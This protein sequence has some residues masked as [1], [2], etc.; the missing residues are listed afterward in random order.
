MEEL[1]RLKVEQNP[2]V[3]KKLLETK[4]YL[5]EITTFRK[6]IRY[7]NNRKPVEIEYID[8]LLDDLM[9]RDFRMNTLCIDKN[10]NII[11][12]LNGREDIDNRIIL[13]VI[14]FSNLNKIL[15]VY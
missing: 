8:N 15:Y 11:D 4:D 6:E 10:G 1:L 9:R 7:L 5:Y 3:L 13:L 2:Y 12:L 14:A